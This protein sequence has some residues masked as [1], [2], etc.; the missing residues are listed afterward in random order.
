MR[1]FSLGLLLLMLLTVIVSADSYLGPKGLMTVPTADVSRQ[2][3]AGFG[4]SFTEDRFYG[5][6][7]ASF[8]ENLE[9]G[10]GGSNYGPIYG[11]FKWRL[12]GETP[13]NPG[14][15]VGAT[16]SSFYGVV[17]KNLTNTGL[18][19][20][21]GYGSERYGGFFGGLS[22]VVNPVAVSATNTPVPIITLMGEFKENR[23]LQESLSAVNFG[24][25]FQFTR[26]FG[27]DIGLLNFRGLTIG[28]YLTTNF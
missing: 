21:L 2:G 25:R 4:A 12:V 14:V 15:A 7:K 26:D 5:N 27:V 10:L 9:L 13:A 22:Y 24:A 6:I 16:G 1:R 3:V 20:H 18:K 11:F 8:V 19:G 17:S 23:H 28:A